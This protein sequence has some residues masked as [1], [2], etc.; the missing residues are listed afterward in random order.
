MKTCRDCKLS[1]PFTDFHTNGSYRGTVKYKPECKRCYL[2]ILKDKRVSFYRI[3]EDMFGSLSCSICHYD[4]CL[5]ALDFHHID[6]STKEI[7]PSSLYQY[8]H[9][10]IVKELDKCVILCSN[11]H[12]EHHAREG[13]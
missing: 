4:K 11:C 12:R 3:A 7:R 10:K 1:L 13:W 6:S 2:T 5:E 8:S 9:D